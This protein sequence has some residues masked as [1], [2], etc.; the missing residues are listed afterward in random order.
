[1]KDQDQWYF[2]CKYIV[3]NFN[4]FQAKNDQISNKSKDISKSFLFF[5]IRET[6]LK[7]FANCKFSGWKSKQ[8]LKWTNLESRKPYH[9]ETIYAEKLKRT[10][11]KYSCAPTAC[12]FIKLISS[13][14][15][16]LQIYVFFFN[17]NLFI[18]FYKKR[19]TSKT[20]SRDF[21]IFK[22]KGNPLHYRGHRYGS[23]FSEKFSLHNVTKNNSFVG[24]LTWEFSDFFGQKMVNVET[25][26][27]KKKV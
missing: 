16:L 12:S 3:L 21:A 11:I 13:L 15:F 6:W 5:V 20:S 2:F 14:V 7:Y 17:W 18:P 19:I 8:L 24:I 10:S 4:T 9:H 22:R 23:F 25:F 1:M 26:S 27:E